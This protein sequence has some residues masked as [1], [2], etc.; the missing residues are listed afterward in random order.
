ML[1]DFG[2]RIYTGNTILNNFKHRNLQMIRLIQKRK[3]TSWL[4]IQL[5]F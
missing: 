5:D 2:K 4:K 3:D 1:K